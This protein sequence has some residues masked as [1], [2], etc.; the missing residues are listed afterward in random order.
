MYVH[1][2][3]CFLESLQV[4]FR[5][6]CGNFAYLHTH[7]ARILNVGSSWNF[8]RAHRARRRRLG[9]SSG[10]SSCTSCLFYA[11]NLRYR[12]KMCQVVPY[13]SSSCCESCRI[14]SP[15]SSCTLSATAAIFSSLRAG[16][17]LFRRI[18]SNHECYLKEYLYLDHPLYE[19]MI[20]L[21]INFGHMRH[22]RSS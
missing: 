8:S 20:N 22:L 10:F 12:R 16:H 7:W 18:L 9:R 11:F 5:P 21:S 14:D 6:I 1:K 13:V 15:W 17:G 2:I 19:Y 4:A 3:C